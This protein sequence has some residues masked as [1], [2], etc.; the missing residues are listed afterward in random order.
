M[1]H[2]SPQQQ[3]TL[4]TYI[5]T[6]PMFAAILSGPGAN[7]DKAADIAK[8]LNKNAVP[9]FIVWKILVS[10]DEWAQAV[11]EGGGAAQLDALTGSK[12]DSLL[13]AISRP[14]NPSVANVRAGLDDFC[15]SQNTLKAA[16]VAIQKRQAN[17]VEKLFSTGTGTM[18]SPATM[19][20]TGTLDGAEVAASMQWPI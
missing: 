15:G 11:L 4:K 8:L 14:L 20:I 18:V 19:T 7:G 9:D 13:W 10:A 16:I 5:E 1:A 6:D 3:S 2:L 12:R 17:Y